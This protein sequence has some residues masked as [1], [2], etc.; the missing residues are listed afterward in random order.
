MNRLQFLP[1]H[2]ILTVRGSAAGAFG[3]IPDA[4]RYFLAGGEPC[5]AAATGPSPSEG[6]PPDFE[7]AHPGVI[8]LLEAVLGQKRIWPDIGFELQQ[9][10]LVV[11]TAEAAWPDPKVAVVNLEMAA[12]QQVFRQ[13]G[14]RVFIFD[15]DNVSAGDVTAI[16][17]I[18]P[19]KP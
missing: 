13:A 5:E 8:S 19:P 12:D 6:M 16:L 2:R 15:N 1:Y 4:Y 11:A 10:G 9:N 7:L 18:I 17:S 14:W 3:G